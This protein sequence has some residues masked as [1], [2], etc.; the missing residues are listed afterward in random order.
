ML[1][2]KLKDLYGC[3]NEDES[4]CVCKNFMTEQMIF[5]LQD[6][7]TCL[8]FSQFVLDLVDVQSLE[9]ENLYDPLSA[10]NPLLNFL[11]VYLDLCIQVNNEIRG[12]LDN[13]FEPFC[14]EEL[15][16][17][18]SIL[19][20]EIHST[21]CSVMFPSHTRS[22]ITPLLEVYL[23]LELESSEAT[24]EQYNPFSSIL[25]YGS[26]NEKLKLIETGRLLAK[27]GQFFNL[28]QP[29]F[30]AFM[31]YAR[32]ALMHRIRLLCS[33]NYSEHFLDSILQYKDEIVKKTWLSRVFNDNPTELKLLSHQFSDDLIY[34]LFYDVRKP[35]IF[36]LIIEFPD[37]VA[38]LL[39]LGKCL[40]HISFRQDLIVHLT[41]GVKQ[42]L[43]HPG[44]HTEQILVAYSYLVRAL[45]LV[46]K[47]YLVQDVVCR[48]VA[49]CL[50]QREDAVRCIVDKLLSAPEAQGDE[51]SETKAEDSGANSTELYSELLLRKP[52][53]V[54]PVDGTEDSDAE[55]VAEDPAF[56]EDLHT[57][58]R[59]GDLLT[60]L[61]GWGSDWQPDP[62]EA[63]YQGGLWR[64]RM[65][66][67][68]MLVSIYGSKK[69]FL[70]EYKQLLSQ[71]LLKQRSFNTA[72]EL[73]NLELLKLRF[74]E[75]NLIEC[76][77]MLKDIR[78]SKRI[79]ALVAETTQQSTCRST[80]DGDPLLNS[81]D[82]VAVASNM[83]NNTTP[84]TTSAHPRIR[85]PETITNENSTQSTTAFFPLS[86]YILSVHYWP[87][88]LDD[89]FKLPEGLRSTFDAYERVFQRLKGNRTLQWMHKLGLVN[90]D[91][92]LGDRK[93]QLDVTPLQA[94]IA[95]LFTRKRAWS[96]RDLAQE[97][98][99]HVSNIRQSLHAFVQLG[100]IRQRSTSQSSVRDSRT[101]G[102][103]EVFE[104]CEAC[105][106][107]DSDKQN[108][109]SS[110]TTADC[111]RADQSTSAPLHN[112]MFPDNEDTSTVI[113]S[114]RE[115]KE[116]ELQVFWS[117]IVAMLTN[118]GGLSLDRIHSMLR[119][120]ALSSTSSLDCNRDELRQFLERKLREC[121]LSFDGEVYKLAKP[122]V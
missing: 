93:M 97:L 54:E 20:G 72:R 96:L 104:T 117:Y 71:R 40:E 52:L 84:T 116:K 82:H 32:G 78:D 41:E 119:M 24:N 3:D 83:V 45:R 66:L 8:K 99:T 100:F 5:F 34:Q 87:E 118:L 113:S 14:V 120:F 86:A 77:V 89:R 91:L 76:E 70:V 61:A 57:G 73:R 68:S 108:F 109:V 107:G 62:V 31:P 50:R 21:V 74:G 67:L 90:M 105:F 29:Y 114:V 59:N 36:S 10:E 47:S 27:P 18:N 65:D 81:K 13:L 88:L 19:Y 106:S 80:G 30:H 4:R 101:D 56:D 92:E 9:K 112:W 46:D 115:R 60:G 7:P 43:L 75:Q 51:Q 15:L 102:H 110:G 64:R 42:R 111:R 121:E 95:H 94:S 37:S 55:V 23:C 11:R 25:T 49:L 1:H 35:D 17:T 26:D 58:L 28:V 33:D 12:F 53:E 16:T 69:A 85:Q 122:D 39:D 103:G 38:A 2:S 79:A 44:V 63:M 6:C 22:H 48:P 98:E